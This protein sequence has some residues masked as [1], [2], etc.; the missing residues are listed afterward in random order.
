MLGGTSCRDRILPHEAPD[1][2]NAKL[3]TLLVSVCRL[4]GI[5]IF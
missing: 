1:V 3:E 5:R 4:T 2:S